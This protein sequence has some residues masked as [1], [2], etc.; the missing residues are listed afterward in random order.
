MGLHKGGAHLVAYLKRL[1]AD[2]GA[3][4]RYQFRSIILSIFGGYR[5]KYLYNMLQN[6][7]P[8]LPSQPA[9]AGVGRRHL[10]AASVGEQH[11]E[12]ICHH[13][14]AGGAPVGGDAGVCHSAIH[15]ARI[16]AMGVNAMDLRQEN[17]PGGDGL[18]QAG[19]VVRHG[20]GQVTDMVAEIQ[21][22]VRPL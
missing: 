17:R 18:G 11:R 2:A 15:A 20:C 4:P 13:D 9:P 3:Q 19:A 7:P 22:A 12:A 8:L 1:R 5:V 16:Q 21:S 10:A 6:T 14:G